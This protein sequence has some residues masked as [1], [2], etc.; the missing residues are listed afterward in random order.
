MVGLE[1]KLARDRFLT[2]EV[3]IHTMSHVYQ[4]LLR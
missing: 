4:L 2:G 3:K 1:A